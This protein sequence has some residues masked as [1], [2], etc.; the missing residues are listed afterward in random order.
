MGAPHVSR[1]VDVCPFKYVYKHVRVTGQNFEKSA[2]AA[3]K[4]MENIGV[5]Y[6]FRHKGQDDAGAELFESVVVV[7]V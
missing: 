5:V 2:D 6:L 7:P 1:Y 3:Y 4:Y